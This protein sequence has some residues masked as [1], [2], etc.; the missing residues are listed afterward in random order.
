MFMR[1]ELESVAQEESNAIRLPHQEDEDDE[2]EGEEQAAESESAE[3]EV[4]TASSDV[5]VD[6]GDSYFLSSDEVHASPRSPKQP[7][8]LFGMRVHRIAFRSLSRFVHVCR[9]RVH[10]HCCVTSRTS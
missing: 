6:E 8:E 3:E 2:E 7:V 10:W 4:E 1:F 9:S 5:D